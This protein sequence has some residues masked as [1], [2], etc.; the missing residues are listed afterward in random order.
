[1]VKMYWL[2]L[3]S[4]LEHAHEPHLGLDA[5]HQKLRS[6]LLGL[7]IATHPPQLLLLRYFLVHFVALQA[8]QVEFV[9]IWTGT[10]RLLVGIWWPLCCGKILSGED[11]LSLFRVCWATVSLSRFEPGRWGW[12]SVIDD[13]R[14]VAKYFRV[15]QNIFLLLLGR[16]KYNVSKYSVPGK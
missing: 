3:L 5:G 9:Q 16:R 10:L 11:Y 4:L 13:D 7:L 6:F 8:Q 14:V 12:K 2:R 1:M 15:V